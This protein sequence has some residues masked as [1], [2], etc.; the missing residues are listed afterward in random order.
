MKTNKPNFKTMKINFLNLNSMKTSKFFI[1]A[2]F[3]LTLITSCSDDDDPVIVNEVELITDVVLT[4]TNTTD[5]TDVV[6]MTNNAPNGQEGTFT[7]TVAGSFTSGA[8][9]ELRLAVT[10]ESEAPDVDDIL[11]DDIIPEADEHFFVYGVNT[12]NLT[13]SRDAAD[14][15]GAGGSKL[16][17][18][19]TWVAGAASTGNV[20][21]TL[22]H[23]PATTDDSN[24]F[25]VATGGEEDFNITFTNVSI[26]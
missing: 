15:D 9:Y 2:I 6:T 13:M 26:N 1:A 23:E 11:N 7:N 20:N 14:N 21:I 25:G 22:V 12:I 5:A 3:C 18:L 19:T 8:T 16:G 24:N 4:F 17:V 10:N